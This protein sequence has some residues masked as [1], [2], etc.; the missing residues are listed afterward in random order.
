MTKEE[1]KKEWEKDDCGITFDDIA[2]RAKD[3]GI[4]DRPR[5]CNINLIRYNVLKAAGCTDA[6][7]YK[8]Q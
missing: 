1:F 8:P 6:E 2:E 5:C 3:W 4:C 7:D